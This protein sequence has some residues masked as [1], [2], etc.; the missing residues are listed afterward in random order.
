[1]LDFSSPEGEEFAPSPKE[2]L[3]IEIS[4]SKHFDGYNSLIF[5][6]LQYEKD[7]SQEVKGYRVKIKVK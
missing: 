3:I 2:T 4:Y 5:A 1:L 7:R 6:Y